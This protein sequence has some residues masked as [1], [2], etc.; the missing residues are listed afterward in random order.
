MATKKNLKWETKNAQQ[1]KKYGT[2]FTKTDYDIPSFGYKSAFLMVGIFIIVLMIIPAIIASVGSIAR[3]PM[4]ILGGLICGF[5]VAYFQ[6]V[7]EKK[8]KV[9]KNFWIVG[10]LLSLFVGLL[11]YLVYFHAIVL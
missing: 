4:V 11:S 5:S 2:R 1:P 7:R 3:W 9:D 6:F 8:E 10:T